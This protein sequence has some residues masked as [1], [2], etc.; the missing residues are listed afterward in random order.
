MPMP[1]KLDPLKSCESC[2]SPL[3]RKR[4]NGRLEDRNV[5]LRRRFCGETCS[6]NGALVET[7]TLSG[8]RQRAQRAYTRGPVCEC[9]GQTHQQMDRHHKDGDPTNN[10]PEN[11]QTLTA[12]CH[13]RLHWRTGKREQGPEGSAD[14]VAPP[15]KR[16]A[17]RSS[18]KSAPSSPA[19]SVSSPVVSENMREDAR[20]ALDCTPLPARLRAAAQR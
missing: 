20:N 13:A 2:K 15:S 8:I 7:P 3:T 5:F 14:G 16:S 19:V 17:T 9:C 10:A 4:F 11:L 12:P 6:A 1:R 18:R